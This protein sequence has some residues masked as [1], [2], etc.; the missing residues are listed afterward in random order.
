MITISNFWIDMLNNLTY[1]FS[2]IIIDNNLIILFTL[3]LIIFGFFILINLPIIFGPL[4]L[5]KK[6]LEGIAKGWPYVVGGTVGAN[7]AAQLY[8]RINNSK[9]GE[10]SDNSE[11][12]E[13]KNKEDKNKEDKNKDD[14]NKQDKNK[15]DKN[16]SSDSKK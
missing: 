3:L 8:D 2:L 14:K 1:F 15:E 11:N 12:K 6:I 13:D 9:S 10:S 5:F 7:S 16:E 4:I